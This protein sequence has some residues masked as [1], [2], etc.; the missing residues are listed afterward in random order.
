[1]TRRVIEHFVKDT[2]T[3]EQR[4]AQALNWLATLSVEVTQESDA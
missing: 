2:T 3:P 4:K 1:M